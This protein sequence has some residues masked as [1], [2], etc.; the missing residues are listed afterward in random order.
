MKLHRLQIKSAKNGNLR[1]RSTQTME[2][3][4]KK[5]YTAA[6]SVC[7]LGQ[8]CQNRWN[9]Q[10]HS[11]HRPRK[12]KQRCQGTI[13]HRGWSLR[14]VLLTSKEAMIDSDHM[15]FWSQRVSDHKK[16]NQWKQ[17]SIELIRNYIYQWVQEACFIA[18]LGGTVG[19]SDNN[20]KFT[21]IKADWKNATKLG[22]CW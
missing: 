1:T 20:D 8:N 5:G 12:P 11:V 19:T 2:M 18:R 21:W 9:L 10:K 3:K 6:V 17:K 13:R 22:L 14:N 16:T 15:V 4:T 7:Y